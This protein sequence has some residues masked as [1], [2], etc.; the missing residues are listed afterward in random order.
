MH[1]EPYLFDSSHLY[2]ISRKCTPN[3][4]LIEIA[5]KLNSST[6]EE[7]TRS[8]SYWSFFYA[9]INMSACVFPIE[10]KFGRPTLL[11]SRVRDM[12]VFD[13]T[14]VSLQR[15]NRRCYHEKSYKLNVHWIL[16]FGS[17]TSIMIIDE[18]LLGFIVWNLC[19]LD[20]A[21]SPTHIWWGLMAIKKCPTTFF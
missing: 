4:N 13:L 14:K 6:Y 21:V 11:Y 15:A 3:F 19:V 5:D 8:K 16:C 1:V 12:N 2:Y 18:Y 17:S 20:N 9:S 7:K 10:L